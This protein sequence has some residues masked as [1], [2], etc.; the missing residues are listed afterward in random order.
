MDKHYLLDTMGHTFCVFS[1]AGVCDEERTPNFFESF[2]FYHLSGIL[3]ATYL[4]SVHCLS[5]RLTLAF[6][7]YLFL[8]RVEV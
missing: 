3:R 5:L 7:D 6:F 8:T 4:G 1:G 2:F